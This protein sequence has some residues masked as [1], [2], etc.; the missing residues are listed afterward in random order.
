MDNP[1]YTN[2]DLD[3]NDI[4]DSGN[5]KDIIITSII[6]SPYYDSTYDVLS[7]Q[8]QM[9][10]LVRFILPNCNRDTEYGG[11]FEKCVEI[12]DDNGVSIIVPSENFYSTFR[13]GEFKM[14][15]QISCYESKIKR[16]I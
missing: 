10:L 8:I 16:Y 2:G 6:N 5:K 3:T 14:E 9:L 4:I 15:E 13:D 11:L 1:S 7:S 12:L